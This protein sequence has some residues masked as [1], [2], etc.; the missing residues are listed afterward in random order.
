VKKLCS[1]LLLSIFAFMLSSSSLLYAGTID[2]FTL[3]E[4]NSEV[5]TFSLDSSPV[6]S[7]SNGAYFS[8]HNVAYDFNG[9]A[10]T[11]ETFYFYTAGLGGGVGSS[12]FSFGNPQLFSGSTSAPTFLTGV[13]ASYDFVVSAPAT[14]TIAPATTPVPEPSSLILLGTGIL[15]AAGAL[16]KKLRSSL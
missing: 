14:V 10:Q 12:E 2:N 1:K 7:T 9:I 16:K 5:F 13:F 6:V 4:N 8:I 15:G 11:P 3:T